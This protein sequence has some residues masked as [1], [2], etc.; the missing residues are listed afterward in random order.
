MGNDVRT[1]MK[2]YVQWTDEVALD[3]AFGAANAR[4]TARL[5]EGQ[6]HKIQKISEYDLPTIVELLLISHIQLNST[7]LL[8][9]QPHKEKLTPSHQNIDI[10]FHAS[11]RT[12]SMRPDLA[13]STTSSPNFHN[14]GSC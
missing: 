4:I 7:F 9:Y 12:E 2:H 1:H 6:C 5:K 14:C 10:S 8:P 11:S 13:S 3:A